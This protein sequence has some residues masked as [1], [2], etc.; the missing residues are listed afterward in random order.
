MGGRWNSKG[1]RMVYTAEH[2]SLAVLEIL[3][4][5][6]KSSV[7]PTYS[8]S[9]VHFDDTLMESLDISD[10]PANWRQYPFPTEMP[11]L[12][13][14]WLAGMSSVILEVPNVITEIESNYLINPKHPDLALLSIDPPR[15]FTFDFTRLGK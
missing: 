6:D 3:V 8:A 9:S 4:N 15:P 1:Y 5:L 10:L 14:A 13:D 12:G 11:R 7:L 2:Y